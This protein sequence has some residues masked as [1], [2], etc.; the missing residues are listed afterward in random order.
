MD[1]PD[2]LPH[3]PG[4]RWAVP[5]PD[6]LDGLLGERLEA[7]LE[8]WAA[9]ARVDHAAAQRSREQW[10]RQQSREEGSLAGVLMDLAEQAV[11]VAV[12]ARAGRVHHGWVQVVGRDFVGLSLDGPGDALVA[13]EAVSSVRV[14]SGA[15]VTVGDRQVK[16]QV[17]LRQVVVGLCAERERVMLVSDDGQSTVV[18]TLQAVGQDV[19]TLQLDG[20]GHGPG[21]RGIA[22]VP[23]ASVSEVILV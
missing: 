16:A 6:A 2:D 14:R 4:Y 17:S 19:A 20:N 3:G 12:H 13:R 8:R 15:P 18:G 21:R 7:R 22:Y 10:M 1:Q 9:A 11:P 23:L 5:A